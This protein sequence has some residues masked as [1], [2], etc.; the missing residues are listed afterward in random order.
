MT[1]AAPPL[2]HIRG[3]RAALVECVLELEGLSNRTHRVSVEYRPQA[4]AIRA[5]AEALGALLCSMGLQPEERAALRAF[6]L[7]KRHGARAHDELD[8]ESDD[9]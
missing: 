1:T 6:S 7:T 4:E 3:I 8:D 2:A 5:H 9:D